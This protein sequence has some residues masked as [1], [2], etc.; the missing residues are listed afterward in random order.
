[1][2]SHIEKYNIA[3]ALIA[4]VMSFGRAQMRTEPLVLPA[5]AVLHLLSSS[6]MLHLS[7]SLLLIVLTLNT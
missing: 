6:L 4:S 5:S 1:M 7:P 3:Y 2:I